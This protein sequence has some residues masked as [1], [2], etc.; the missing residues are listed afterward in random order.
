MGGSQAL[1]EKLVMIIFVIMVIVRV[2]LIKGTILM[3]TIKMTAKYSL[4]E[5]KFGRLFAPV[6][7]WLV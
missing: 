4:K 2:I 7:S 3:I 6:I 5:E 1:L